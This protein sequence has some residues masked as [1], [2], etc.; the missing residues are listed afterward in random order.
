LERQSLR[1]TGPHAR[2]RPAHQTG[3]GLYKHH[4]GAAGAPRRYTSRRHF[5]R[6]IQ[7]CPHGHY[8]YPCSQ[9]QS[10]EDEYIRH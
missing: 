7:H 6:C 2:Y 8:R 1:R 10:K 5:A 3:Y 4:A 9:R